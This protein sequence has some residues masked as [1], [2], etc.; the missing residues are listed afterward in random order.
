MAW[1]YVFFIEKNV[2]IF[3]STCIKLSRLNLFVVEGTLIV[4]SCRIDTSKCKVLV[5]LLTQQTQEGH[6]DHAHSLVRHLKYKKKKKKKKC[7]RNR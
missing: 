3:V 6:L 5:G 1:I 7:E 2:E 4:P